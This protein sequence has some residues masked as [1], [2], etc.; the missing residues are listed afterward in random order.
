VFAGCEYFNAPIKPFIDMSTAKVTLGS[1]DIGVQMG[2]VHFVEQTSF[3]IASQPVSVALNNPQQLTIKVV[4]KSAAVTGLPPPPNYVSIIDWTKNSARVALN[5][6]N[7][8]D[9]CDITLRVTSKDGVSRGERTFDIALP[10]IVFDS[11][12]KTEVLEPAFTLSSEY[13]PVA[14]WRVQRDSAHLGINKIKIDYKYYDGSEDTEPKPYTYGWDGS[15]P[16]DEMLREGAAPAQGFSADASGSWWNCAFVLPRGAENAPVLEALTEAL[17]RGCSFKVT[18]YDELGLVAEAVSPGFDS[19]YGAYYV[20]KLGNSLYYGTLQAAIAA[21]PIHSE[22]PTAPDEITVLANI[23]TADAAIGIPGGKYIKLQSEPG[24]RRTLKRALGNT[25]ALFTVD[26]GQLTLENIIIDGGA[27]WAGTPP[28]GEALPSPAFSAVNNG[29]SGEAL[30]AAQGASAKLCLL[31]GAI[32]QNNESNGTG[33]A[34]YIQSGAELVIDGAEAELR[35]NKAASSGGGAIYAAGAGTTLRFLNGKIY[36]N[37][38]SGANNHGGAVLVNSGNFTM[39]GG[40]VMSGN[41][42]TN[43]GGGVHFSGGGNF[44]MSG[45]AVMSGNS[46]TNNGGGVF[47]SNGTFTMQ[48]SAVIRDN[49]STGSNTNSGG[50]GVFFNSGGNFTMQDSAVMS[51]NSAANKGGGVFVNSGAFTMQGS[52]MIR[53]NISTDNSGGGVFFIGSGNFTMSDGA[54]VSGNNDVYLATGKT[55]TIDGA[56]TGTSP[57]AV[58]TPYA[59]SAGTSVL[60]GTAVSTNYQKFSLDLSISGRVIGSDGRLQ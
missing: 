8:G 42:T 41:S 57:V 43:N 23:E 20:A 4:V 35:R 18:V 29:L 55:I 50:G 30:I 38:A 22:P 48:D 52:A 24:Q 53:D 25:G 32:L 5:G 26:G 34:V 19:G 28:Q 7:R 15:K 12:L 27:E 45:G 44:T 54:V 36:N 39:S 33:G 49:I 51:G 11:P 17:L 59:T 10:P 9:R 56:L 37:N 14:H 21:A 6:A 1:V 3:P 2:S 40:A 16:P 60:S 58:I 47:V 13:F 31:N 46:A